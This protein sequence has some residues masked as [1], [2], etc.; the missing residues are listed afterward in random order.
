MAI[1]T[2]YQVRDALTNT[3]RVEKFV[4]P[5]GPARLSILPSLANVLGLRTSIRPYTQLQLLS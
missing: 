3:R 4:P 5:T 2:R 1:G